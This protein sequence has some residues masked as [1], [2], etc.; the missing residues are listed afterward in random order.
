MGNE[1]TNGFTSSIPKTP[2]QKKVEFV[3]NVLSLLIKKM[4][5]TVDEL[6]KKDKIFMGDSGSCLRLGKIFGFMLERKL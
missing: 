4:H 6:D 2:L 3:R 1:V 5:G